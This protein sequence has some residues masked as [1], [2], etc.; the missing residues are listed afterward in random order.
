MGR[1]DPVFANVPDGLVTLQLHGDTF[2]LP[3]G[4]VRLAGSPAYANQAFRYQRAYGVQFHLEISH[5][6]AEEWARVPEYAE[7]LNGTLG[8]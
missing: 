3:E 5:E 4:A 2:D 6:M 8:S 7:S 1:A